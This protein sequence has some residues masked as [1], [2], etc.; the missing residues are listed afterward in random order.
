MDNRLQMSWDDGER[1]FW[2]G[3]R[4]SHTDGPDV[5]LARPV[6]D[7][8]RPASLDRFAHEFSLKDELDGTWAVRPLDLVR[9]NGQTMLVLEDPGGEPLAR[10]L[11]APMEIEHFFHHAVGIASVLGQLHQRGL[12][13][14]DLKPTHILVN[15]IGGQ[16]RLTGFG[17]ASRL[18]RERQSPEPPETIAGTLA[19]M[20]PEQTGRMNRSIDSRS[21]LYAF[22][23]TLYQ[24]LTGALPFN[25][26]D[27]MEW[28]H[29][30]IARK[31]IPPGERVQHV[32]AAVSR[33][34][35]KL[36]AKTAEERYQ[37]AAGVEHDLRH[38]LAHWQHQRFIEAFPLGER[39][40]SDKLLIPEKLY[41][42]ER[43]VDTL[44][45]A[46]DRIV[47]TGTPELLLVS[48]YSGIGKSS[49]VNELHKLLVPPRGIFASGKFD[50]YKRDIPYA[51]LIQAFQSL[52]RP[53]L[54][55]PD[56]ELSR[57]RIA[58]LEA[59]DVNAGLMTDLIPDL[60]LI[61]GE[62]PPAPE[63]EPQ[64]AQRRFMQV[65]QR[66]I[67]VF[68]R[69][70]HPLALFVDDL[71]WLDAAT[72]DL[73]EDLLARPD[74]RHLM[75]IGA[76][77]DN[78]VDALHPLMSKLRAI[79][80]AGVAVSE[81]TLAPLAI[82]HVRQLT[83]EALHCDSDSVQPLARLVHDKTA[84]NPF[85][86]I[87]FLQTLVEGDLL[88]FDHDVGKWCWDLDLIHAKG[89]T[90]NV[91][92]L[93]IG[94][95]SRLPIETQRALQQL[96]CLGN[97]ASTAA[98][99]TVLGVPVKQVH[100]E[101]W[102]ACR[103]ELV[104]RLGG[105]YRFGHDRIHEA[106]YSLIPEASRA[107]A[108]LRI[109]RLLAEQ[110]APD[111]RE[112]AI[113]EIVGQ[114]N[115]GAALMTSSGE[116]EQLAG[117]NL[118]AGQRAKAS[119][120]YASALTYLATGAELLGDDRWSRQHELIF[121]LELN[122]AACE[123]LTG[124][125]SLAD[126]RLSALSMRAVTTVEQA[127]VAC[128]H[129]DVCTTLDKSSRAV[130][131]CLDYLRHVG[132]DWSPHPSDEE[133]RNEFDLIGSLLGR[134]TI[135]EL[136]D[137]P[138]MEDAASLATA[139]VLTK[140]FAPALQTDGNLVALMSCKAIN[141]S[142]SRGNCDASC[143]A[144]VL[145][146]RVAGPRFG[147]YQ[148][149]FRFG[150][151]GYDL[152]EQRGLKRFE[153]KTYL[154]FSIFSVR[155]MKP[156]QACR[157]LLRRA[158]AA[159]NR[160]GDI[161]Y[162][163]YS[164]NSMNSDL[165]F[166]GE[167]LPEAQAE[168]ER[169]LAYVE[170]MHFG[171]VIDFIATQLALIRTLRGLTPTFGSFD[172]AYFNERQIEHRLSENPALAVPACC[173]WIRK[174]QARYLACDFAGALN[175]AAKAQP[176][177]WTSSSFYE[178]SDFHF[179][180]ALALSA[181]SDAAAF[182]ERSQCL[183]AMKSH[184][185][186]LQTWAA[187]C[188]ENFAD[189]AALVSA[190]IARIEGRDRDAEQSYEQAIRAAQ[191]SGF[192]H[193]EALANELASGF[194]SARGLEKIARL[195]MRDARYG[196][197]RWRADGK[198]RQLEQMHP[199]LGTNDPMSDS[200]STIATPVEQLDLATVLKVSQAASSDIV[201]EKLIDM[202]MRTAIE[203]AGAERG[204]L[205]LSHGGELRVAAEVTTGADAAHLQLRDL[206]VSSTLLPESILYHVMRARENVI[207]DDAT[208]DPR[209]ETDSYVRQF[210]AR[211]I[212]CLPL[213]NPVKLVGALYLENNLTACVFSP[214]RIAVLKLVASQ[215]AISL[216][217]ARLYRDLAEREAKIRRLVDANI[218]G[219]IV[220]NADGV[221]L[222]AN[223]AFLRMVGYQREDFASGLVRWRDLTPPEWR[224]ISMEALEQTAQT[225]RAQPYEKEYFRKDGS[226]VPVI[227][228]LATFEASRKE[229]VAFVLDLTERKL[230]EEEARQSERRYREVQSE[231]AH[232]NRVATV[233]QLAA[234]IAHE[235][236]QPVSAAVMN[237]RVGLRWL[238]AEPLEVEEI[239]QAFE[240]IVNDGNR[241]V[242]VVGK[243]RQLIK[244]APP[245]KELVD[246]NSTICEVIEL[247]RAEAS[248]SNAS[249]KSQ[250]AADLPLIEADHVQLQ[251]VLLNLVINALEAMTDVDDGERHLQISTERV[252][253]ETSN[254]VVTVRDTGPGFAPGSVE[255][256]F[257]PF[258]TTKSAG[259]GMGLSI[260][261]SIIDA[262]GGRMWA[263]TNTPRGA[264]VQFSLPAPRGV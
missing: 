42:R 58:L 234:S 145:L 24:M 173:Y 134:R 46:F 229:G 196:Y 31:P 220:W 4:P 112:E 194:Y 75:L 228:G 176:L 107:E 125:S 215:A 124:Q 60:K 22:G 148:F 223:D 129:T 98:L 114:L 187:N 45:A 139:E 252:D 18:P 10:L 214:A 104:E 38:C 250:L 52:V 43:E 56:A 71:Q 27:P 13:H 73:L 188:P 175:A 102:D 17:L 115:R 169:G 167:P 39:D 100:T 161:P 225:G 136:I 57:W 64:Q 47:K 126:E 11:G 135:E 7:H 65:F 206:P 133:V 93:M 68:A 153:A 123:F 77:R 147:D 95:L 251:Q 244:K 105:S 90:D 208:I 146:S 227:V 3:R 53:L 20:A 91:V 21:D 81:I 86:V 253:S 216:E 96:A 235:V 177:L 9:E 120:A 155:W 80:E 156:V 29:C 183:P 238:R 111:R 72:L 106:S 163:A 66:F 157:D 88:T 12:V 119:T 44:V 62:P 218:I 212:L 117:F 192:V 54:G 83:E 217:N 264:V 5:L 198:V 224:P 239:R 210:R 34:V 249:V 121:D 178:E 236:N 233:G 174:L 201:L 226:R 59:L 109:G 110:T 87:Q 243:I 185:V 142:L 258:Y 240:R 179:Y 257:T 30:H 132:I 152:V 191:Q 205:I 37:T 127:S 1:V 172:D 23:V 247:T 245:S 138:L 158:F 92:D 84:G 144:Y 122:R 262:F 140:L 164:C 193:N 67:G 211:S 15:C 248:R 221:I 26:V 128:L 159:A 143:F 186:N 25:A 207:L 255:K 168:A 76:Y 254:I 165:L 166:A 40:A 6:A 259:L 89:Y 8:P 231:L 69:E 2:R 204:L 61:I 230:A 97:T 160:L 195:Y 48:G 150:Q 219:I 182:D 209:F 263:S 116:R 32:P 16:A 70:E 171:L 28:V 141:L 154:C 14:K 131:V 41:G 203:Q 94:K 79:R 78:E 197:Q 246:V 55:K 162:A 242:S 170:R 241:A 101:L 189:R 113:F 237:A 35:M 108:H 213:M 118:L 130:A 51:T 63:L 261:S 222:E 36:L 202:V 82:S 256:I 19:Y 85:F 149:G 200:T 49:V 99:S 260:C 184:L 50:Q 137:L 151:L 74:L 33:I 190:E 199:Y 103:Q 180:T 232:A 181:C